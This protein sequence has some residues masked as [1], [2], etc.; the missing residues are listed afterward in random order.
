M[1]RTLFRRSAERWTEILKDEA[2]ALRRKDMASPNKSPG[3][4][5]RGLVSAQHTLCAHQW[6]KYANQNKY[7]KPAR[8][9]N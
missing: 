4:G 5:A 9:A 2:A 1:R 3:R 6:L 7:T 8:N